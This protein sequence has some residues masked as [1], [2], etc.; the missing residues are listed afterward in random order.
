MRFARFLLPVLA[1]GFVSL[2]GCVSTSTEDTEGTKM[3]ENVLVKEEV[4]RRIAEIPY[5]KGI[6]LVANLERL[7][8]LGNA[9]APQLLE[10][11]DSP[12]WLTRSSVA[13]VFGRMGNRAYIPQVSELLDDR[14][15][16]V[17]YQAAAT[18]V[19]L[20]DP[21]GFVVLVDGLT[22][23]DI[24]HRFKCIEAL[25]QAT[26][27]DFG[28]EHDGAPGLRRQAVSRWMDWLEEVRA[29]AL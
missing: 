26:A 19:E 27:Q 6:E 12:D 20:G 10:S 2:G 23:G 17:R 22:D 1:L 25:R 4:R 7:A 5:M 24:R 9:A 21:Q 13:W 16:G 15:A 18:L 11:L 3:G 29:S 28:Y 8:R 14:V